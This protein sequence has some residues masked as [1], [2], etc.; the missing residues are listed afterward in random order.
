MLSSTLCLRAAATGTVAVLSSSALVAATASSAGAGTGATTYTCDFGALGGVLPVPVSTTVP[1]LPDTPAAAPVPAGALDPTLLFDT[2]SITGVLSLLTSP[3]VAGMDLG[4]G[5]QR[6]PLQGFAFGTPSGSTLPASA[7]S[8]AFTAPATPGA[9][10]VTAP[11]SFIFTGLLPGVLAPTT[12][13]APCVT[14]APAVLGTLTVLLP[15]EGP[16]I[17][18]STTD[19]TAVKKRIVKGKRARIKVATVAGLAPLT[20]AA[21]GDVIVRKRKRTIGQGT[22]E[23]GE[24]VIRT[25]RLKK[26]GRHRLTVRYLG[27]ALT[28]ASSDKVV[29][30]V[31]RRRR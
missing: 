1:D 11:H 15:G 25:Q 16:A 21:V 7:T 31:V 30:R 24:T 28:E 6:V 27:D 10:E 3:S 4:V 29:V 22:L 18:P 14:D 20:E 26:P 13:S 2:T 23:A 5:D 8:D 9:Y 12:V 19:A 17:I